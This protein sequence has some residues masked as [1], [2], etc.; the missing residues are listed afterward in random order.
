MNEELKP[1]PKCGSSHGQSIR[2]ERIGYMGSISI[3]VSYHVRCDD[4]GYDIGGPTEK[5]AIGKWNM[6]WNRRASDE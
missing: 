4:C 5:L 2:K 3:G 6:M 1:C